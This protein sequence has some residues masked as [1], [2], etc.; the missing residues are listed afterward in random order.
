MFTS[1]TRF[2]VDFI[3]IDDSGKIIQ[4]STAQPFSFERH[5]VK[6]AAWV[7]EINGGEAAQNGIQVAD[8]VCHRLLGTESAFRN[9]PPAAASYRRYGPQVFAKT[10]ETEFMYS[11]GSHRWIDINAIPSHH[12]TFELKLQNYKKQKIDPISMTEREML[13]HIKTYEQKFKEDFRL[14]KSIFFIW[15]QECILKESSLEDK[16][17][18]YIYGKGW[19][20]MEWWDEDKQVFR[21]SMYL[22]CIQ[23][24]GQ[25]AE[26][27]IHNIEKCKKNLQKINTRN[28]DF[29]NKPDFMGEHFE[30]LGNIWE[31]FGEEENFLEYICQLEKKAIYNI[32]EK[33]LPEPK[34]RRL[35][36]F[37]QLVYSN[38]GPYILEFS[39]KLTEDIQTA[40]ILEKKEDVLEF[41]TGYPVMKGYPNEVTIQG[42][43]TWA[44][45]C[46][47]VL[48]ADYYNT[49][50]A[51]FD[52]FY[53]YTKHTKPMHKKMQVFFSGLALNLKKSEPNMLT[54]DQGALFELQLQEFL[55]KNP[56]KTAADMPPVQ[57]DIGK[58]RVFLPTAYVSEYEYQAK[59]NR[60]TTCHLED[61]KVYK[62]EVEVI[63]MREENS[64]F[65]LNL[66]AFEHILNGYRPRKGD[67][68][69]GL[70]WLQGYCLPNIE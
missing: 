61:K 34:K 23:S 9:S 53:L 6:K 7:L 1:K 36:Q 28:A 42:Y 14:T 52:P 48:T 31:V 50:M 22:S 2:A 56:N 27:I 57:I 66:Y 70:L 18:L 58:G 29:V 55:E 11:F 17:Y 4:I 49:S 45:G 63:Q 65:I 8:V 24:T 5:Q 60:V 37:M 10:K 38:Y 39:P 26:N 15:N 41:I 21:I 54:I 44:S 69:R 30:A 19:E 40:L 59:I 35:L 25:E 16:L 51:W 68:V 3:F 13:E 47:G 33:S 67:Y 46:E 12:D 64:S 20:E 62:M 32:T 43:H